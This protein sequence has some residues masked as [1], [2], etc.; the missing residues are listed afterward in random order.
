MSDLDALLA[1]LDAEECIGYP[2]GVSVAAAIRTLL[3]ER[4][5]AER[6][7]AYWQRTANEFA[8]DL[9]GQKQ[10]NAALGTRLFKAGLDRDKAR[11]LSEERAE[12][13][14]TLSNL[15]RRAAAGDFPDPY[16]VD[17]ALDDGCA[18]VDGILCQYHARKKQP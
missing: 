5:N 7:A 10:E 6:Q 3:A 15:L 17:N 11:K 16:E 13:I 18:C 14:A 1:R 2:L 12:K 4:D 8:N 9:D